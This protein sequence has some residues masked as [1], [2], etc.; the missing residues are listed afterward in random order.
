[1]DV[2]DCVP[3]SLLPEE[4][5]DED[6]Q[7]ER[8]YA[9]R[10]REHM[11][12]PQKITKAYRAAWD[13][14]YHWE[15]HYCRNTLNALQV[16]CPSVNLASCDRLLEDTMSSACNGREKSMKLDIPVASPSPSLTIS[17]TDPDHRE[18]EPVDV[19]SIGPMCI[20]S[21]AYPKY[22]SCTPAVR[23]IFHRRGVQEI[24]FIPYA[25]EAGFS[26][27]MYARLY[28]TFVWQ[29]SWYDVDFKLIALRALWSLHNAEISSMSV[30]EQQIPFF[31]T[32]TGSAGLLSTMHNRDL[33]NWGISF[34]FEEL[35]S[36]S[37]QL[38]TLRA[39][40]QRPVEHPSLWKSVRCNDSVFCRSATCVQVLCT[41]HGQHSLTPSTGSDP[42]LTACPFRIPETSTETREA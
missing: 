9:Q 20:A 16:S 39:T 30:D 3:Q 32:I 19:V 42:Q 18:Y 33:M 26:G 14:F 40:L 37:D 13:E 21:F 11:R 2:S 10:V 35:P 31:P 27:R 25:D 8:N 5:L 22:E 36:S 17:T 7:R 28:N 34:S 6:R 29:V 24:G 12:V 41:M 4:D 38:S 1:M 15:A 23:S